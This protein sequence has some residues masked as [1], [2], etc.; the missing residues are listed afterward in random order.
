MVF[1]QSWKKFVVNQ[2][3]TCDNRQTPCNPLPSCASLFKGYVVVR[4]VKQ[5][6][7]L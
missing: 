2:S 1:I 3:D 6:P 7:L 5:M 4:L